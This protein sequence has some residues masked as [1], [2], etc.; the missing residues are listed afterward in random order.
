[1]TNEIKSLKTNVVLF[2]ALIKRKYLRSIMKWLRVK[3]CVQ[4]RVIPNNTSGSEKSKLA[5]LTVEYHLGTYPKNK[6]LAGS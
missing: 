6:T 3:R 5:L 4:G 1:M 2:S